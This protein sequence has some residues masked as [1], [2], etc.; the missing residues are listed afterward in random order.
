MKVLAF[1]SG[2]KRMGYAALETASDSD[3]TSTPIKLGYGH[4]GLNKGD[5]TYQQ[6]RLD[7]IQLWIE[8]APRLIGSFSPD[9]VVCEVIPP[10]GGKAFKS[11]GIQ[12]QL[13]TTALTA[14]QTVVLQHGI[15]LF[16]VAAVSVKAKIGGG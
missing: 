2:A 6:L 1:D 7:L 13:A 8:E 4:L 12:A 11:N 15:K 10:V 9:E 14:L 16:Q 3:V 5:K